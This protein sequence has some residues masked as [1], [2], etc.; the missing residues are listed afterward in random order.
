MKSTAAALLA[1]VLLLLGGAVAFPDSDMPI[2]VE[3]AFGADL[4]ADPA[5]WLFTDIST[6]LA[7]VPITKRTGRASGARQ[8][9]AGAMSLTLDNSDGA[10]TPLNAGSTYFPNVVLGLPIRVTINPTGTPTVWFEGYAD[11]W[12]PDLIPT[13][14]DG[15]FLSVMRVTASGILRR[16]SQGT[17]PLRSAMYRSMIGTTPGDYRPYAYWPM[18]DGPESTQFASA[19]PGL[20]GQSR[21][22]GTSASVILADDATMPGSEPVPTM[23]ADTL[24]SFQI[25]AYA[26]TGQWV[27]QAAMRLQ[28]ANSIGGLFIYVG[29][30]VLFMDYDAGN[31]HV[32]ASVASTGVSI[33]SNSDTITADIV[34]EWVSVIV[35][36]TDT[37]GGDDFICRILDD[38]GN[39]IAETTNT[40]PGVYGILKKIQFG[41]GVAA[42]GGGH[43]AVFT[44]PAFDPA[45]DGVEGARAMSGWAGEMAHERVERLGR[46]ERIPVTITGTS[47]QT[48]GPQT[49]GT[50]LENLQ[51]CETVNTGGMGEDGFGLHFVCLP[52]RYNRPVDLA[53]DL[54]TYET[55]QGTS[56]EVLRPTFDDQQYRNRWTVDRPNGS[57]AIADLSTGN[58]LYED[59]ATT[60]VETDQ[61]LPDQ[62]SWR[63]NRDSIIANRYAETPI[64]LG[65]N[66]GLID[67]WLGIVP[68]LSRIQRTNLPADHFG[69]V[70]DELVDGISET[71]ARRWWKAR[72]NGSPFA[73][74]LVGEW[75]DA[76]AA[77]LDT[78]GCVLHT[79]VNSSATS[80]DV[81]TTAGPLWTADNA[82]DGWYW[83]VGGE[84]VT[85][86]DLAAS[87]VTYGAVGAVSH[88]N[89]ASVTPGLP[90]SLAQ[91]NLMVMLAAIRNSGAGMPATPA[92]WTRWPVF[93]STDNVQIFAKIAGA[94][95]SGPTVTF[96]GGV[97]NADTSAQIIRLGGKW[98]DASFA[99]LSKASA[100]NASAQ[101]IAYP[102]LPKLKAD[103][104][105]VLYVGWKQ[106]DWTSVASPGTEIAEPDTTTGDDQGIVWA[107]QIQ[108]SRAFVAPGSFVVTGGAGAISRGAVMAI[109]C[110][111]QTA[112]V[113]RSVNGIVKSHSAGADVRLWRAMRLG[114]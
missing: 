101:D 23:P 54:A 20:A 93:Q 42:I 95:E 46:E 79:A 49:T 36:S 72:Y 102:G 27:I 88:A 68:G 57:Q 97:A 44:D 65:A 108:T 103:D 34:G 85:V 31:L 4:T 26:D 7:D 53:I 94:S 29:G 89:N 33:F 90:A 112:T 104:C 107:Y 22:W 13:T 61:Q 38:Q 10:L 39:L 84:K 15:V 25:P 1:A 17:G 92:G 64:D 19:V 16:L 3:A 113:T 105:I 69:D 59:S 24:V 77:K 6:R 75:D 11:S 66:T 21:A 111:V 18:E 110:D 45:A 35:A 30:N 73:A 32:G 109:R 51:E 60:N 114:L 78:A 28:A 71:L 52:E 106:D 58:L 98:H 12:T 76:T 37:P 55:T 100:L 74:Y 83:N 63:V 80:F 87:A 14:E 81:A 82:Q 41:S 62:A 2:E 48:M 96:T 47:S 8:A 50:L 5:S 9:D 91:G 86:T 56:D 99:L 40:N 70:H 43:L 67:D